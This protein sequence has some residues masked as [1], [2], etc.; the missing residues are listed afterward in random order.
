MEQTNEKLMLALIRSAMSGEP[1]SPSERES[2][3]EENI[4]EAL[5]V[6]STHDLG[7]IV[8]WGLKKNEIKCAEG[9]TVIFK[10]VYR[11]QQIKF[12]YDKL[13]KS[14]EAAG[15]PFLPLKG[16]VIRKYYPE[17]WMRTSCDIDILVHRSDLDRVTRMLVDD[18]KYK[19]DPV[20]SHDISLY[21]PTGVHVEMHFDLIEESVISASGKLLKNVWQSAKLKEGY[22]A[23]YEMSD[24]LFY[25]YH[26][27]H[28]AKHFLHGGCGIKPF[29]DMWII[30]RMDGVDKAARDRLLE[31]GELLRF[32]KAAREVCEVWFGSSEHTA[33]TEQ[34]EKYILAGGVYGNDENRMT[35]QLERSGGRIAYILSRV[36]LP[37]ESLQFVYPILQVKK[38]CWMAPFLQVHRWFRIVFCGGMRKAKKTIARSGEVSGAEVKDVHRFLDEVGLVWK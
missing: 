21:S 12:E 27:A 28:M 4:K 32:T 24:D 13:C 37:Y 14:F 18:F 1:L 19:A 23:F 35:V 10:S 20:L 34:M 33:L 6:A 38:N 8:A 25:L 5:N 3:T 29:I 2:C 15:I 16:S 7:Q 17:A 31:K 30:D 22:T 9:E 36:F 26:V 11:Y